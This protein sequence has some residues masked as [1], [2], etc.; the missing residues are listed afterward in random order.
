MLP[1][2]ERYVRYENH[3]CEFIAE[4]YLYAGKRGGHSSLARDQCLSPPV[5][6]VAEN[7]DHENWPLLGKLTK[8]QGK[9]ACV[10]TQQI[11][12]AS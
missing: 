1:I 5:K 8:E 9:G 4:L 7:T 2:S 11:E 10:S 6:G 12:C 3:W